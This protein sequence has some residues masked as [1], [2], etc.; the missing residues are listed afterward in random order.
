MKNGIYKHD[1]YVKITNTFINCWYVLKHE[2][3]NIRFPWRL[4]RN[5][6]DKY[7]NQMKFLHFLH[8]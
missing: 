5:I 4:E 3:F 8:T 6:C 1:E 2:Y 7:V